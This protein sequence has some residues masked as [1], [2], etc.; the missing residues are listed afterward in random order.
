MQIPLYVVFLT[1]A[2]VHRIPFRLETLRA[3]P[4]IEPIKNSAR[5]MG[6]TE[7]A[8]KL[9]QGGQAQITVRKHILLEYQLEDILLEGLLGSRGH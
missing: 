6:P 8:M 3:K 5:D 7:T 9:L 2:Q 1:H 4:H